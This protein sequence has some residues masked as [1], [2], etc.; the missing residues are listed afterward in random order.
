[1]QNLNQENKIFKMNLLRPYLISVAFLLLLLGCERE[2]LYRGDEDGIRFS[3][4]TLSFDTLFTAVGSSTKNFKIYNPS[5]HD[6]TIDA[7]QLA[8]G[9]ESAYRLNIN[10]EPVDFITDVRIKG[11]DSL[12]VFVD[13]NI[14]PS[15][16]DAPFVVS[17][18][19][20]VYTRDRTQTLQL[21]AFGQDVVRLTGVKLKSQRL[22][23]DKPYLMT[24]CVEVDSLNIVTIEKGAQLFFAKDASLVVYGSLQVEGTID[25]PVLFSGVRREAWYKDKP[26][27]WGYIHLMPGSGTSSFNHAHIRNSK[28][29]LVIDSVGL[30]ENNDIR[31]SNSKIE[32]V[33]GHGIIAQSA[34]LVVSNS[35]IADCG[36]S[37]AA[38]TV[39]GRYEFVH[40][41]LANYY[42]WGFRTHP[43]VIISNYFMDKTNRPVIS[44]IENAAF[45]N[46]IVYGRNENELLLDLKQS[47]SE[48]EQLN[49][50][51]SN[52]LLKVGKSFNMS[53]K[54]IFHDIIRDK[55]PRFVNPK[56][57]N[58]QL[59]TLS[60]AK[61]AG[62]IRFAFGVSI[63]ILGRSRIEDGLPDL[64][65][66]ERMEKK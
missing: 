21:L 20:L 29:G 16:K 34:G 51:F 6:M 7:I 22:T 32:H 43:S 8:G 41:T 42:G 28:I 3:V 24:G 25:E 40:C 57:N 23:N 12:F 11:R 15:G 30:A 55:D 45:K 31:I 65:A 66:Y 17:D 27:Q 38:L 61:D 59:D 47:E 39:G 60:V 13:V 10:G 58:F 63:D 54:K 46:C 19:V 62:N 37:L 64:G 18:S 49:V 33:S 56:E 2:Y 48:A 26:G 53:D 36:K 9:E 44:N 5:P 50:S 14:N 1:M 52:C 35:V 4:D